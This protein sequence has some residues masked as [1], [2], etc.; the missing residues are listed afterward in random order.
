MAPSMWT[1]GQ[2]QYCDRQPKL[3]MMPG[4]LLPNPR[5]LR[6]L[7]ALSVNPRRGPRLIRPQRVCDRARISPILMCKPAIL[8]QPDI[9]PNRGHLQARLTTRKLS[10]TYTRE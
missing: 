9:R 6:P 5:A 1:L 10:S 2:I 4:L 8:R 3:Y 7:D